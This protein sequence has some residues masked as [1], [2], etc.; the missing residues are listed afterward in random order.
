MNI[1]ANLLVLANDYAANFVACTLCNNPDNNEYSKDQF[2]QKVKAK[3]GVKSF[4]KLWYWA[5][6]YKAFVD[7]YNVHIVDSMKPAPP[8]IKD[9]RPLVWSYC[10]EDAKAI[11]ELFNKNKSNCNDIA[12][13]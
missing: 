8:V 11:K 2:V 10:V 7:Y 6:V 3:Y 12:N 5:Q 13:C 4:I 1:K 9:Y